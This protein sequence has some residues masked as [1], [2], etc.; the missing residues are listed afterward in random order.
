LI[1]AHDSPVRDGVWAL[2]AETIRRV[3]PTPT[4]IEWDN[5]VPVWPVLFAEARR[6]ERTMTRAL[7]RSH[8]NELRHAV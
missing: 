3:G 5:D 2:Y 1:D 6:A 7:A 4:L 8:A